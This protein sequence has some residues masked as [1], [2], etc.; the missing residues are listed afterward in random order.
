MNRGGYCVD[1]VKTKIPSFPIPKSDA[2]IVALKNKGIPDVTEGDVAIFDLVN[3][4]HAAYVEKVHLDQQGR[5]TAID[6]S[7][8]NFGRQISFNEYNKRWGPKIRVNGKEPS[9]AVSRRIY[10]RASVRKNIALDSIKQI[11]SPVAAVSQELSLR[12]AGTLVNKASE[13]LYQLIQFTGREL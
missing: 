11:W 2:E 3:F 6:V 5:A 8:M 13:A 4:W 10:D 7:E 9:V 1:Y 12:H